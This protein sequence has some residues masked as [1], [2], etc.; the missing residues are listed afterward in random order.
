MD[1][2]ALPTI[3]LYNKT[4][5]LQKKT[6][7]FIPKGP[8]YYAC[9]T[10]VNNKPS[11]ILIDK[12]NNKTNYYV[13][14]KEELSLGTL[15]Y[16]TLIN[17]N[18]VIE[19]IYYYKNTIIKD[20]TNLSLI[21]FIL[22]NMIKDSNYLGS[23]SF[24]L[25]QMSNHSYILECS[26]LPYMTYGIL[27]GKNIFILS[28]ILGGFQ[29]KKRPEMED[30]YELFTL[31]DKNENIFYSTA[32]V[33]DFKTSHFLKKLFYKHKPTYKNIEFSDNESDNESNNENNNENNN[34]NIYVGCLYISEFK[35]WKPYTIK[36]QDTLNKI[37]FLEKKYNDIL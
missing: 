24:K 21:K 32:L 35:K 11:C 16:G 29:I 31:N 6:A 36:N 19:Y 28:S 13:C 23:I 3:H 20:H 22:Q 4:N 1:I 10:Y 25:P 8:K 7:L 37:L 34:R 15:F 9:F 27:Q 14:F 18:F 33:N 30:V 12:D 5:K 17:N 26:N 2:Q